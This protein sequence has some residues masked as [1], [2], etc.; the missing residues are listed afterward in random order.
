MEDK[1]EVVKI[2]SKENLIRLVNQYKN[3]IFSI[4]LKLTGDYF[5]AEDIT[6]ETFIAAY[7][8]YKDFDGANEKAWIS[9]IAGN[10]CIDYLRA[11]GRRSIPTAQEDMPEIPSGDDPLQI[12]TSGE[13]VENVKEACKRLPKPY[14]DIGEKHFLLGMT[15]KEIA[16][17]SGAN[18]KTV[19]TQIYRAKEMLKKS[20]RKEDFMV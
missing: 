10:K 12:Y 20:L 9:R 7:Q 18:I 3:L 17:S 6:Q 13:V 16:Q 2:D 19:Q 4:C 14:G 8:H 1:E 5:I 15:A 11:A